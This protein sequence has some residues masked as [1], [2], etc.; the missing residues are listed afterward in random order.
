MNNTIKAKKRKNKISKKIKVVS[1]R[2]RIIVFK[3]IKYDYI[4]AIDDE[5]NITLTTFT[6]KKIKSEKKIEKD[7]KIA[8]AMAE[9]LNSKK[10]VSIVF[11]R[12]GYRYH[13]RIKIIAETLR[14][15]GIKF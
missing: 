15:N 2:I 3:S 11:D 10:I 1:N 7:V 13:G 6:T 9:F 8:E 4:Q 14:K 12:R 5:K